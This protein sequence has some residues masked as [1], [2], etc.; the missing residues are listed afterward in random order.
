MSFY[1]NFLFIF[2][3]QASPFH[4]AFTSVSFNLDQFLS[5]SLS[6]MGLAF[7]KFRDQPFC[8]CPSSIW[9]YV[10]LWLDSHDVFLAGIQHKHC[11]LEASHWEA[12]DVC[13]PIIDINFDIWFKWCL[14][15]FSSVRLL[16]CFCNESFVGR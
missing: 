4:L 5:F 3:N 13:G 11:V 15:G 8:K 6:F 16:F 14:P 12:C 2:L 1:S 10:S 7:L 9:V